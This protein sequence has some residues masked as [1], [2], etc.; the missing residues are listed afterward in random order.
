MK[1][2]ESSCENRVVFLIS[3]CS[4]SVDLIVTLLIAQNYTKRLRFSVRFSNAYESGMC[5]KPDQSPTIV[6]DLFTH[7]YDYVM[8]RNPVYQVLKLVFEA[9][10]FKAIDVVEWGTSRGNGDL[11]HFRI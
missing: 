6:V 9:V 4:K 5:S 8:V 11:G 10:F 2:E 3:L 7:N 1:S